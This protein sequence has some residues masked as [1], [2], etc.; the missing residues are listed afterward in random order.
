MLTIELIYSQYVLMI[1]NL[2]QQWPNIKYF[3][4]YSTMRIKQATDRLFMTSTLQS[5]SSRR[6]WRRTTW[7]HDPRPTCCPKTWKRHTEGVFTSIRGCCAKP[8]AGFEACTRRCAGQWGQGSRPH[9][10]V[11]QV[12]GALWNIH[13]KWSNQSQETETEVQN[14]SSVFIL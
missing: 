9:N 5:S 13:W 12:L 11:W 6:K 2:L 1:F 10:E 14:C 3:L 4:L 7:G 8:H